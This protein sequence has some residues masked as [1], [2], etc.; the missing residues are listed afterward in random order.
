MIYDSPNITFE[1]VVIFFTLL[2]GLTAAGTIWI[3]TLAAWVFGMRPW[4]GALLGMPVGAANIVL[5]FL[6]ILAAVGA[7]LPLW[8]DSDWGL[9]VYWGIGV[10]LGVGLMVA[11][12]GG[13][14]WW[15]RTRR[16]Q[17]ETVGNGQ[18]GPGFPPARE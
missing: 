9:L 1:Q 18:P 3:A 10:A 2:L 4:V 5:G 15:R 17:H 7:G 11:G 14:C 13:W 6:G 12:M 16:G 8:G